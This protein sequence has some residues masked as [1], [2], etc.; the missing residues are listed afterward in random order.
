MKIAFF[1]FDGTITCKDS[2]FDFIRF[3]VGD[4]RFYTGLLILFPVLVFFKIGFLSNTRAKEVV[5]AHFFKG[6][7]RLSFQHIASEY[8]LNRIPLIIRPQAFERIKSHQQ[9]GHKVVVVS[10]SIDDWLLPWCKANKIDL[11]ATKLAYNNDRIT[12]N[13][14]GKNCH[15]SEKAIRIHQA[16]D[17][18]IYNCIYAY[19]DSEG[20]REMLTMADKKYYK[21]FQ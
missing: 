21:P 15:G 9:K 2:L 18:G 6:M 12:G 14:L 13:F 3:A 5:L 8:S 16:Y 17:V 10:A 19:G 1:D 7:D 4:I 11:I 20:D